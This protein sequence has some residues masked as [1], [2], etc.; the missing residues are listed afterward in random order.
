MDVDELAI[1]YTSRN[2]AIDVLRCCL[3]GTLAFAEPLICHAQGGSKC[4]LADE[5]KN[6]LIGKTLTPE[7]QAH[8]LDQSHARILRVLIPYEPTTTEYRDDRINIQVNTSGVIVSVRC[9]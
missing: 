6:A 7:I 5:Q 4:E 9:G 2:F 8:V 3:C 1:T